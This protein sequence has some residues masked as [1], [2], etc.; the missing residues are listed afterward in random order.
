MVLIYGPFLWRNYNTYG[1]LTGDAETSSRMQNSSFNFTFGI[2]NS[3]KNIT[4]HFALPIGAVTNF[5]D[6]TVT[7][8]HLLLG[9]SKDDPGANF[10]QIPYNSSFIL[11]EN[12]TGS[13]IHI[14]LLFVCTF[15]LLFNYKKYPK[16][17]F[18]ISATW[19]GFFLYSL[20]FRWQPWQVRLMLP[21]MVLTIVP[22]GILVSHFLKNKNITF[23]LFI[24][25]LLL[26]A[27]IPVYL[28]ISKPIIDPIGFY[29]KL[30]Q[31]PKGVIT[32]EMARFIPE[33]PKRKL[34]IS[35]DSVEA[36]YQLKASLTDNERRNTY[37]LE[38]SLNLFSNERRTIFST[39]RI[40]MYYLGDKYLYQ[41]HL[42]LTSQINGVSPKIMLQIGSDSYEYPLWIML[43]NKFGKDFNLTWK[44]YQ[45]SLLFSKKDSKRNLYLIKEVRGNISLV[46]L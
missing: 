43:R 14:I 17:F 30:K 7:K 16:L 4:D 13:I 2:S 23:H 11:S 5:L 37:I 40:E 3:I 41:R 9:I 38:D 27:C 21:W 15:Y 28:N 29:R 12:S 20:V 45:D 1:I 6:Q 39:S 25:V 19:I 36:G 24:S 44:N 33:I 26:Y 10:L 8:L 34:L 32:L 22:I 31:T 18:F 46:K 42:N 35:Y